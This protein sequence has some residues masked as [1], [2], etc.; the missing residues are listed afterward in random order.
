MVQWY[1]L[2]W[3]IGNIVPCHG[4]ARGSTPRGRDFFCYLS[5]STQ[6]YESQHIFGVNSFSLDLA[7]WDFVQGLLAGAVICWSRSKYESRLA[8]LH[9]LVY[10]IPNP[11]SGLVGG[12]ITCNTIRG[13]FVSRI[14]SLQS[15]R[16]F[17]GAINQEIR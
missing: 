13:E 17:I 9:K 10:I 4:T 15:F 3:C 11:D 16:D 6:L 12:T 1:C 8:R 5:F 14:V 7:D 2:P